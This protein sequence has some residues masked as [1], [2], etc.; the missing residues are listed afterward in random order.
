MPDFTAIATQLAKEMLRKNLILATA[1]SCTGG[2]IAEV[3]T[4]IAGS[5]DWFDCGFVTY[6]ND[7]K[8]RMLGVRAYTLECYGAVSENTVREMAEGALLNSNALVSVATS[9]IAGPA[10]GTADKPVG[11]VWFAWTGKGFDSQAEVQT[12]IGDREAVRSQAVAYA[13]QELMALIK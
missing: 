12:F 9:G 2:W 5:S 7:A 3:A 6:S 11:T 10:G 8:Q 4:A 13:L 1:E